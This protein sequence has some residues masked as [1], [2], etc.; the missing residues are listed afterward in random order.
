MGGGEVGE[1]GEV[2]LC[3]LS[4]TERGQKCRNRK[5]CLEELGAQTLQL[6]PGLHGG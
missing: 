4:M 1:E 6:N 2:A 3:L 5:L